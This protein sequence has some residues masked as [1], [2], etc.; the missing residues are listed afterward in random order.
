VIYI[1]GLFCPVAQQIRY[2]G[3]AAD[4]RVRLIGHLYSAGKPRTHRDHW[5]AKLKRSGL[6][7][8]VHVLRELP[9]G[10]DWA[11]VEREEIAKG[12][13]AG[14]PLTNLT[15]GGEGAVDNEEGRRRRKERMSAP[16]TRRRLSASAKARWADPV[17]GAKGR[18]ENGE[19]SRRA[20]V[21]EGAKRRA[22]D[23]YRQAQRERS[24]AAWADVEKRNRII[25]GITDETR[26]KISAA[27]RRAWKTSPNMVR[28]LKNLKPGREAKR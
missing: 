19:P 23:E 12:F 25:S 18:A 11:V 7:P 27:S 3:K 17:K 16:E 13:A 1:Y 22:T 8:E 28:C 4:L 2:V 6:R 24:L 15:R 20:K 14:W 5:L 21:S 9:D 10:A 26:A